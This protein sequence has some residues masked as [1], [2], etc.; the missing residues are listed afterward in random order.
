MCVCVCVCVCVWSLNKVKRKHIVLNKFSWE[1]VGIKL[2]AA[3]EKRDES[4]RICQVVK[5]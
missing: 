5:M 1:Y 3:G 4:V 2:D